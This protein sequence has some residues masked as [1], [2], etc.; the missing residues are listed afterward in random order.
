ML[1]KLGSRVLKDSFH[2]MDKL[3]ENIEFG[4]IYWNHLTIDCKE[5][6]QQVDKVTAFFNNKPV[7]L[8]P[9]IFLFPQNHPKSIITFLAILRA[10]R[11]VVLVNPRCGDLELM[12]MRQR[13]P[14]SCEVR[15]DSSEDAFNYNLE[16]KC[17][18]SEYSTHREVPNDVAVVVYTAAD[19]GW[20][21]PAMLT[22]ENILSNA[23]SLVESA[24]LD[25]KRVSCSL[26]PLHNMFGLQTGV[27][28][29][30][31][32]HGSL[33][34]LKD[35]GVEGIKDCIQNI[36]R[37]KA[38]DIYTVPAILY[39]L[40]RSSNIRQALSNSQCITSGGYSLPLKVYD[41]FINA[42][43]KEIHEGYG[44][45]EAS[46]ICTWHRPEDTP[47]SYSVGRALPC[48]KISIADMKMNKTRFVSCGVV[49]EV[50]ITGSNVMRGYY[51]MPEATE[52]T[53]HNGYLRTG[54]V[55][56]LDQDGFLYL[57]G[58]KK[59]M[60]NVGG[61]NVYP[62]EVERFLKMHPTIIQ[63]HITNNKSRVSGDLLEGHL[64]MKCPQADTE[65][66]VQDVFD[67]AKGKITPHKMPKKIFIIFE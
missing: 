65:S 25:R 10:G 29:P 45:T 4:K 31:L 50:C 21:K 7:N 47:K 3:L 2:K 35:F 27:L 40:S 39:L 46:P 18:A 62:S 67:W 5:I 30:I 63:A 38:T 11:I 20:A 52:Y 34:L 24:A 56:R 49:G 51:G 13:T 58:I 16:F 26:L 44:L 37:Y 9:F 1:R 28:A 32:G 14:P 60:F 57:E 43:G 66:T 33:I 42:T 6:L 36:E 61:N 54:D 53:L 17:I 22:F 59:R 15:I 8:S 55:G 41:S 12:E 64:I 19:D 48:C 23:Q